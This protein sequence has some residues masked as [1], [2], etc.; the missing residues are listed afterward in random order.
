MGDVQEMAARFE[1]AL[2]TGDFGK[3]TELTREYATDDFIQ[4]WPQSGERLSKAN[5]IRL[6]EHYPEMAGKSPSFS[7]KRMLPGG[8]CGLILE[9]FGVC[10]VEQAGTVKLELPAHSVVP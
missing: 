8:R 1:A 2:K 10:V 6:T 3:V 9:A 5:S 4:D 7:Y